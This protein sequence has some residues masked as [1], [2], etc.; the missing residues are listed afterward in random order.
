MARR[1]RGAAE[2]EVRGAETARRAASALLAADERI[3]LAEEELGFVEAALGADATELLRHRL[4]AARGCLNDA[5]RLYR[6]NR[7]AVPGESELVRARAVRIVRMCAWVDEVLDGGASTDADRAVPHAADPVGGLPRVGVEPARR[8]VRRVIAVADRRLDAA[9]DAVGAGGWRGGAEAV[10]RLAES[11]HL[12][13]RLTHSVSGDGERS[14]LLVS[15]D[16]AD[17]RARILALAQRVADLANEARQLAR[18]G[19]AE[20]GFAVPAGSLLEPRTDTS[21]DRRG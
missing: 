6:L 8:D 3:G 5:F 9:R 17:H 4:D 16:G 14:A 19:G 21:D 11:E 1:R 2:V 10:V 20:R 15:T 13:M 18:G 12:R 7:A